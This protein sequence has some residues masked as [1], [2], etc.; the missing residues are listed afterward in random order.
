[1]W[2]CMYMSVS[3]V[4]LTDCMKQRE[5]NSHSA[6]EEILRLL[7]NRNVHHRKIRSDITSTSTP[8]SSDL[9]L[10]FSF[11]DQNLCNSSQKS[12][13]FLRREI[14][15]P[16]PN[17][18]VGIGRPPFV[19]CSQP[20]IKYIPSYPPYVGTVSSILNP[21]TCPAVETGAHILFKWK[22]F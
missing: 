2:C 3:A 18:Q 19:G 17:H 20:R 10:S 5:A 1:L 15:S 12:V 9:H 11:S 13:F 7:W 6:R 22:Y 21:R 8:S 16:S 14:A 4:Q